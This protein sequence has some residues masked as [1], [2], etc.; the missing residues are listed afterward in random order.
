MRSAESRA[1]A[2]CS[3]LYGFTRSAPLNDEQQP[4]KLRS[5]EPSKVLSLAEIAI[6]RVYTGPWFKAVNF[7]LRYGPTTVLTCE[8]QPYFEHHDAS[9]CYLANPAA[10]LRASAD[11]R[12]ASVC[13]LCGKPKAE[14]H[15]QEL[16]SWATSC[17]PSES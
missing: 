4:A 1:A 12:A 10:S 8:A 15:V 3:V 6:L 13:L 5:L 7:Y 14:H 11:E 9:K 16:H 2:T 17:A